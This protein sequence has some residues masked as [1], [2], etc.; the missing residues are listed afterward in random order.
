M[1]IYALLLILF[2]IALLVLEI[3]ILPGLIAGIVGALFILFALSW[4]FSDYGSAI[5]IYV[6]IATIVCTA[7]TLYFALRSKMWKRFSL[8]TSL[9]DNRVNV[10]DSEQI[11]IGD[12]ALTL[13]ALRPMGTLLIGDKKVEAQT[14]GELIPPNTE[15]EIINI[16]PN[17]LIVKSVSIKE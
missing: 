11:K 1:I 16:Q 15:V 2:G 14:N 10:V 17:R 3:L 12:R 4:V 7:L 6:S 9:K 8:H 5:G 13:S